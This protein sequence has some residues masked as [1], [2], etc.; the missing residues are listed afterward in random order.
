MLK[1][2]TAPSAGGARAPI[3]DIISHVS[4]DIKRHFCTHMV[5]KKACYGVVFY[6][7]WELRVCRSPRL[8]AFFL[9]HLERRVGTLIRCSSLETFRWKVYRYIL[10]T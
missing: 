4:R 3:A 1:V 6:T 10:T 5:T 9:H 2:G 8:F 7:G